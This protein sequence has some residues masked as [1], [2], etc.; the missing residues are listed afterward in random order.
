VLTFLASLDL[1]EDD[2]DRI[3]TAVGRWCHESGYA[4]DSPEGRQAMTSAVNLMESRPTNS[5]SL[6]DLLGHLQAA[7]IGRR[8]SEGG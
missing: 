5:T 4:V 6:N 7:D 8:Q 3:L 2:I 1:S